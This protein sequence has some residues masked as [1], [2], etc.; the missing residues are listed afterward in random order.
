[1]LRGRSS[2]PSFPGVRRTNNLT[3]PERHNMPGKFPLNRSA[4]K[5]GSVLILWLALVLGCASSNTQLENS[6]T[7]AT[8]S[9]SAT[10]NSATGK[11]LNGQT[12]RKG[13]ATRLQNG[14]T[15]TNS[16]KGAD[17]S[18]SSVTSNRTSRGSSSRYQGPIRSSTVP[19]G[20]TARC[21]DGTYSFSRNRRGTCSHHGGVAEWL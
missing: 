6:R 1:M 13:N 12:S 2:A 14:N 10:A 20:A 5:G 7:S 21:R 3:A 8:P 15:A 18:T 11:N 16:T 17:S 19:A 4:A 9:P